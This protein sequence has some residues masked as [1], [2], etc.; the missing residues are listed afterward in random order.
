MLRVIFNTAFWIKLFLERSPK[1]N[2]AHMRTLGLLH[3]GPSTRYLKGW[4]RIVY[5]G[6]AGRA[7]LTKSVICHIQKHASAKRNRHG[8]FEMLRPK[9]MHI[10][11]F[12][13][14]SIA[15]IIPPIWIQVSFFNST[16]ANLL[17][18][19]C[20]ASNQNVRN[21]AVNHIP[22]TPKFH[23]ICVLIAIPLLMPA[24]QE[25]YITLQMLSFALIVLF[26][27]FHWRPKV[28]WR[29]QTVIILAVTRRDTQFIL[30][31]FLS[32]T[33]KYI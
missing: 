4:F 9:L 6:M 14:L 31:K 19:N 11:V 8:T 1:F 13:Y 16:L 17:Y 27:N 10:K 26:L 24:F 21:A 20:T 2:F 7:G 30:S 33:T 15:F 18:L 12:I 25:L 3:L 32:N 5:N 23:G 29:S 22:W 28:Y